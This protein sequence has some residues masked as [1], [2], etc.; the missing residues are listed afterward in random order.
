MKIYA[1]QLAN[2]LKDSLPNC[3]LLFGDEPFQIDDC[4]KQIKK[5][6]QQQ[7]VEE[8]IRLVDDDQFDW[9]ELLDHCQAMSLFASKKLIELE[10]SSAKVA[11]QAADVLQQIAPQLSDDTILVLFGP[12]L[13]QSQTR[14]AWF[15]TLEKQACYIPVYEI[16]GQH[17][18][19]W[20]QQQLQQRKLQMT[21]DAQSYLLELTA[22]N[23]LACGQELEKIAMAQSHS[24]IDINDVKKLVADQS[25]FSV[26]QLLDQIWL[27]N[28]Q[29]VVSILSRLQLEET[30]P[31]ILLW[32]LQ[33]DVLLIQ[34][35]MEARQFNLD[36]KAV[37]DSNRVWKNKQQTFLNVA[38]KIPAEVIQYAIAGLAQVDKALKQSNIASV[39]SVFAH[40]CL[41]L[42]GKFELMHL[43]LPIDQE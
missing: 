29:K 17:L 31:N 1:N 3:F 15:K 38:N 25:R 39:Y 20:L 22:G 10:L 21:P 32:S 23:L 41:L 28:G 13:E 9:L 14:A 36:N 5:A 12:K 30:E 35:L 7:G 40:L 18:R 11:K 2:Q 37:F 24:L 6:A 43:P 4:R 33:K 42:S 34:Q 27:G 19:R 26:F 16:E 8:F